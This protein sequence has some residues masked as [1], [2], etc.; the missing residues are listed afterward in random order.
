MAYLG[1]NYA[2]WRYETLNLG[3]Q[4]ALELILVFL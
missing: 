2:I 4:Q 1:E 3:R